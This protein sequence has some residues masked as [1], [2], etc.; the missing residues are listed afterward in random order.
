VIPPQTSTPTPTPSPTLTGPHT[1][2]E[3][4]SGATVRLHPGEQVNVDLS[5]GQWDPPT[6][7]GAAVQRTAATG[8]YPSQQP[9]RATFRAVADG[10]A[11]LQ[12]TTD[13][14]CLHTRPQCMIAQRVWSVRVIVSS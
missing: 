10:T 12:S 2:T 14:A 1:L 6:A 9:A 3:A 8:G 5:H 11:T 7:R 13:Y 4:D